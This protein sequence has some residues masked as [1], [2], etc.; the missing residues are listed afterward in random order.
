VFHYA[1]LGIAVLGLLFGIHVMHTGA[2]P[3]AIAQPV[4]PPSHPPFKHY[5]AG[6]GIVEAASE[7]IQI[8]TPI[9]GMVT[10]IPVRIGQ[11]IHAGDL[12]F[13]IDTR[14]LESE[15]KVRESALEVA[16][17]RI[18]E[19]HSSLDD[20]QAQVD[21]T[22]SDIDRRRITA[23]VTGQVIQI[24]I[25][26]GEYAQVGPLATPLTELDVAQARSLVDTT[27]AQEPLLEIN[28]KQ[29]I[30]AMSILLGEEPMA[31]SSELSISKPRPPIP[32]EIP[33]GLP[34]E[35][36]R[37]RPDVRQAERSL[38]A[39]TANIGVAVANLFPKFS[40]TGSVGQQ[41]GRFGLIARDASSIWSIGPTVSWKI[42]DYYQLQSQIRVS[43]AQ[44][45]EALY[46]YQQTV[47]QSF[48]DVEDALVAYAQDQVRS[49]TI[50]D[51]VEA[52]QKA[53]DLATQ[54]YERG[55]GDFLNVQTAQRGLYNA[56]LDLAVSQSRVATDLVQLYKALGGGWDESDEQKFRKF[57]DPAIAVD[58]VVPPPPPP[59]AQTPAAPVVRSR[60][61]KT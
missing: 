53:V 37:R 56:H 41:S 60:T 20:A 35:L 8:S 28:I 16:K 48:G 24:K 33:V 39:A 59:Q 19:M 7:N 51:E 54:L 31:L 45:Q 49:K 52:N 58:A 4:V 13:K 38:A 42:L 26:L 43:N 55:L 17:A 27:L 6:A 47:L 5:I 50:S 61:K 1:L 46:F 22:R 57:E 11:Q 9:P 18:D 14:D 29:T 32:S 12:L 3:I 23:P 10:E 15:L 34:S 44:Q 2:K 25:H 36:L 40:L 30:H 21:Q